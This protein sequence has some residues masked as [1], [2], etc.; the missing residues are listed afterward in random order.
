MTPVALSLPE[1]IGEKTGL[2]LVAGSMCV[3]S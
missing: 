1:V 3:S 2:L